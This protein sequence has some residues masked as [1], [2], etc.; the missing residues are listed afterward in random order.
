M[1]ILSG[2]IFFSRST[3]P[4]KLHLEQ[5]ILYSNPL[6]QILYFLLFFS[7]LQDSMH[8]WLCATLSAPLYFWSG[9]SW[10][11]NICMM[12]K[13]S[14][15]NLHSIHWETYSY[16]IF[17]NGVAISACAYRTKDLVGIATSARCSSLILCF[18]FIFD[19]PK[20]LE[21][22]GNSETVGRFLSAL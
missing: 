17:W 13:S 21:T 7:F 11:Y 19:Y 8:F 1:W 3:I 14:L 18:S 12:G 5:P 16:C 10:V 2:G 6:S 4:S 15:E 20:P 9:V 22:F